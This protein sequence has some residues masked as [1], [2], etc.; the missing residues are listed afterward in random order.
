MQIALADDEDFPLTGLITFSDN[1]IDAGTGTLR[2]R[3]TIQN[4]KINRA[5]VH[6]LAGSVRACRMPVGPPRPATSCP[7]K[8]SVPIKGSG[9]SSWSMTRTLWNARNVIVGQRYGTMC[10]VQDGVVSP[11]DRVITEGLLRVA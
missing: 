4:T 5:V 6:D 1:Q 7:K 10:V 2:V 11:S 8:P 3:A 9:M